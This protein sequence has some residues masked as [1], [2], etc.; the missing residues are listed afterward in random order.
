MKRLTKASLAVL[1]ASSMLLSACSGSADNKDK[2]GSDAKNPT[3]TSEAGGDK[4]GN[5]LKSS[6][7]L[8]ASYDE[9]K[10]GGN[11]TLAVGEVTKQMN[12]FHAD[13]NTD[14][15]AIFAWYNPQIAL[16][17]ENAH[18][19]AN[20]DYIE[21]VKD[22]VVDGKTVVTWKI[23]PKATF[24]DGTPID[25]RAFETVWK[26]CNGTNNDIAVNDTDGYKD[27]ESVKPGAN[28]KEVVVTY[29]FKYPWWKKNFEMIAHP[30]LQ[31]L[32]TFNTGY[33]Q[34]A[35]PEWG[36]GPYKIKEIDFNA[37]HV[38]FEKN[39]KWWGQPGKLDL[40]TLRALDAQAEINAFKNGT[41]D[42]VGI[43]N[44][45]RLAQTKDMN[46]ISRYKAVSKSLALIQLNSKSEA[47]KDKKVREAFMH[48]INRETLVNIRFAGMDYKEPPL[49]SLL[50][51]PFQDSYEDNMGELGKFDVEK[52][53]T[54]LDEAGWK[55]EGDYRTKDGKTL[56]LHIPQFS[57]S[58]ITKGLLGALQKMTKDVGMK[59]ELDSYK[60]TDFQRVMSERNFDIVLSGFGQ[61]NP[62]GMADVGQVYG[63]DSQLS[64]TSLGSP[65]IDAMIRKSTEADN[66]A[67]S[68]KFGNEAEK[69]ALAQAGW[70][71]LFSG[72]S[73]VATKEGLAN[74]GANGYTTFPK[75]M[76]GWKK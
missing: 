31:D 36:A 73:M 44:K 57:E 68:L 67:E 65:E 41:V 66:E 69:A 35:H 17:D 30:A 37:G 5:A 15:S 1:A 62:F 51:K 55:K 19:Y 12:P 23:N 10:D 59:L 52:A 39:E 74:L 71:P 75:Q 11:L 16:Y 45:D 48:A 22:E 25:W 40:V 38:T 53:N 49:G 58:P 70:L 54:L 32:N 20:P 18:W 7:Y 6:D 13:M 61:S 26:M 56:E 47:F 43:G 33:V 34:N 8:A 63:S 42:A 72:P 9:L 2:S 50:L 24:N 3:S 21:S 14:T 76:L 46:G 4:G 60:P 29:K 27:M 64:K 28:D